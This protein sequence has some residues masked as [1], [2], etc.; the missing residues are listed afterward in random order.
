MNYKII[1]VRESG[2]AKTDFFQQQVF[3]YSKHVFVKWIL[4]MCSFINGNN[5]LLF[6]NTAV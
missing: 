2:V 3:L 6:S 1:T 4:G 5:Y